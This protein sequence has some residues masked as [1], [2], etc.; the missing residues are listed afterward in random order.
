MLF[1]ILLKCGS[2]QIIFQR[3]ATHLLRLVCP[4]AD[5]PIVLL[6]LFLL[7]LRLEYAFYAL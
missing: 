6:K 2:F 7:F 4:L 5:N 1:I 3:K